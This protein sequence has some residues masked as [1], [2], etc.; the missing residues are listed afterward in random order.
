ME[1][2]KGTGREKESL[3]S[4][5][6]WDEAENQLRTEAV[7]VFTPFFTLCLHVQEQFLF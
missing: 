1:R 3:G 7:T 4:W 2:R 6:R 5:L